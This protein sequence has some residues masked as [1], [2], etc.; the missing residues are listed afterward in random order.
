MI[1]K[2]WNELPDNMKNDSVKRYYETLEKKRT[3]LIMKRLFDFFVAIIT[4]VILLP[5]FLLIS[6]AIKMDSKGPVMFRQVRITQYGKP[7]KIFKFRT[8]INNAGEIGSQITVGNDE[9]V[10]KVGKVLRKFRLDETP[11][12]LNIITGDMTFVGTR[13]EVPKYLEQYTDE[14]MATLLLPAGVTNLTCIYYKN[15]DRMLVDAKNADEIYITQVLPGKMKW[16][17]EDIMDFSF[18]G[19][20]KLLFMTFLAVCGKE[21]KNIESNVKSRTGVNL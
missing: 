3:S 8:M 16:N 7:F 4:L 9:R 1:L 2:S 13:P 12:L 17:L 6:I 14:M 15:E 10:T 11:Q 21:Y 18:W 5:L 20:T 19:D